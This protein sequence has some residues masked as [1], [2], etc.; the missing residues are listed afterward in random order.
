[1]GGAYRAGA[2]YGAK[3]EL[4]GVPGEASL[5]AEYYRLHGAATS[6]SLQDWGE[7]S[8]TGEPKDFGP[9]ARPGLWGGKATRAWFA[10]VPVGY[11]RLRLGDFTLSARSGMYKRAAPYQDDLVRY[12]GDFDPAD[13]FERDR[14]VDAELAYHVQA[15]ERL[16]L[17]A[18]GFVNYNMYESY[19]SSSAQE[20]C[21][22]G[23]VAGCRHDLRGT[24]RRYGLELKA[25]VDWGDGLHQA[26]MV[27]VNGQLRDVDSRYIV[28]AAEGDGAPFGTIDLTDY[29]GAAFAEHTLR[30][31]RWLDVNVGARLDADQRASKA[32]LSPRAAL[33]F[34]VWSGATLKG[35]YSEAF[36]APSAYELYYT[37]FY[38][39]IDSPE[40]GPE[41]M[42]SVEASFEQRLGGHRLFVTGFRT[43]WDGMVF[44]DTLDDEEAQAQIDAGNID[45]EAVEV[46]QYRNAG[47]I[48]NLG[49]TAG[50]RVRAL[51]RRLFFDASFTAA[52]TT[53]AWEGL[54]P[55]PPTVAPQWFG[56]ARISYD[57]PDAL[58]VLA[59]ASG[60][61]AS[62]RADR[63]Y[64]GEFTDPPVA[65]AALELKATL[66]GAIPA[67]DALGYRLSINYVTTGQAAYTV[68][69]LSYAGDET[70]VAQLQPI[71]RLYAFFGLH[72]DFGN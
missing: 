23:Q 34:G 14:W 60:F 22:E 27:G 44:F 15:S 25:A 40:L 35:I 72:Y 24:G 31:A 67:L 42:R 13:D 21:E 30:P 12:I 52:R 64:D 63:Y 49:M 66:S 54:D 8:T 41:T 70:S 5:H 65:P 33:A 59:L 20:D 3:F 38:S 16:S 26:T 62:R 48:D 50:Y 37:D 47:Q 71:N 51:G 57:L 2:G 28:H 45:P 18:R 53:V 36:R 11:G 19:L 43:W 58:P 6:Y 61:R 9:R 4:F 10:E 56:N 17:G 68:G 1:V 29:A 46:S 7:D 32:R 69:A 39:Q 55:R